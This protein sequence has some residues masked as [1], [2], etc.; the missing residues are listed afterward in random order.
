PLAEIRNVYQ[1]LA[2]HFQIAEGAGLN[3]AFEFDIH[4]FCRNYNL[5]IPTVYNSLKILQKENFLIT[6]EAVFLPSRIWIKAGREDLYRFQVA[7][8]DYDL[9]L[10]TMLRTYS[11]LFNEFTRISEKDMAYRCKFQIE[12][13]FKMIEFM[14]K[15]NI[16]EYAK[17]SDLPKIIY[18][19]PRADANHISISDEVLAERKQE[20]RQRLDA[21]INYV[22]TVLRCRSQM[23]LAYFDEHNVNRCGVCDVCLKRNKLDLSQLDFDNII[24]VIKPLLMASPYTIE[25]LIARTQN[26]GEE[27]IIRALQWLEDNGKI[28]RDENSMFRWKARR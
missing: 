26:I 27:K 8:A 9:L 7:N 5:N 18:T 15:E 13:I 24:E 1:A 12:R 11:G 28:I 25:E 19:A 20:A 22:T 21:V 10:K 3:T 6:T 23:L 16:L 2:N 14:Q 17:Q 4:S